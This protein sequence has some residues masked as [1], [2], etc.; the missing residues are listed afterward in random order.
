MINY[1][2]KWSNFFKYDNMKLVISTL[3]FQYNNQYFK[4]LKFQLTLGKAKV[5]SIEFLYFEIIV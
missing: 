5:K 1:F 4:H 2:E 3:I